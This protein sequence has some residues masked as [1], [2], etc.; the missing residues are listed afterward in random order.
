ML[1]SIYYWWYFIYVMWCWY[2][3]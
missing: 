3:M 1:C 2:V